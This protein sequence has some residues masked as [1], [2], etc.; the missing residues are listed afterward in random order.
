M[1]T[2]LGFLAQCTILF[3]LFFETPGT[4]TKS[5]VAVRFQNTIC[6]IPHT[7]VFL[8]RMSRDFK[9]VRLSASSVSFVG[10]ALIGPTCL[11]FYNYTEQKISS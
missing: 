4:C 11:R 8:L 1:I 7:F 9:N 5:A 10:T 3:K 2:V 6:T